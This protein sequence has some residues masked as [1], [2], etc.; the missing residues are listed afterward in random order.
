[1]LRLHPYARYGWNHMGLYVQSARNFLE[2]E[3][4]KIEDESPEN[5]CFFVKLIWRKRS[6]NGF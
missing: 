5:W 3:G 6:K 2:V 1:M 4:A